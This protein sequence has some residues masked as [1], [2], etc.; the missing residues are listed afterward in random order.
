M[1]LLLTLLFAAGISASAYGAMTINLW[2]PPAWK[3]KNYQAK[4][5]AD[6][7]SEKTGLQIRPR[8]AKGYPEILKAFGSDEPALMYAGSFVQAIVHERKLGKILLQNISGE[9]FYSGVMICPKEEEP[10]AI[11]KATPEQIAFTIGASSGESS[12]KAATKGKASLGVASHTAAA[13]AVKYGKAEAAFVKNWWWEKNRE[14]F[15]ELASHEI[16]GISLKKNP[17]YL[18]TASNLVSSDWADKIVAAG[19]EHNIFGGL[20]TVPFDSELLGFS[21]GLMKKGKINPLTYEW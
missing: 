13:N 6:R 8:I 18:L 14:K 20:K 19:S 17:D 3:S 4:E 21:I 12:A 10:N 16:P 5:I 7:L 9:E 2:F 1:G 15:P 11:L